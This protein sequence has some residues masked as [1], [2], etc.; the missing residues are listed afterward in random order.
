MTSSIWDNISE[1]TLY[2]LN[3]ESSFNSYRINISLTWFTQFPEMIPL[4][5]RICQTWFTPFKEMIHISQT[6]FT[7]Y[8]GIIHTRTHF[9]QHDSHCVQKWFSMTYLQLTFYPWLFCCIGLSLL[10]LSFCRQCTKFHLPAAVSIS[11]L[12][13]LSKSSTT[14]LV[15]VPF[16]G[17]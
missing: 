7:P 9:S 15:M 14:E 13:Q 16:K 8:P 6:W 11:S 17:K 2:E 4:R 1:V 3:E 10:S 5:T 12:K